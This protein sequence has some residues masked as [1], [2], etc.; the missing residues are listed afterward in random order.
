[1]KKRTLL[2]AMV[3]IVGAGLFSSGALAAEYYIAPT[4][5]S[6]TASSG[7]L[8]NPFATF[9]YAIGRLTPG[10]TLY[11]RGGTYDLSSK[12]SISSSKSGTETLP[13]TLAAYQSELPIL[14]FSGESSGAQGIQLDGNYWTIQGLT[15][16][17]ARDS[18]ILI[19]G[20]YNLINQLTLTSNQDSG[21]QISGSGSLHPSNNLILNTDSYANYDAA[22]HGENADG[23]AAKFRDLGTGNVFRGVRAWG[24]SDD[25]FD[26]W[27]AACGVT[28]E[29]SW[30]FNNGF[31]NWGDTAWAG[32]GNGVKLG[33]DSGT[34][35]IQNV[36]VWGN[37][38]NGIDVNG[39]AT[40]IEVPDDPIDHG[41]IVEN[42]TAYNNG[43][44]GANKTGYNFLFDESFAH[45]V[46]NNVA[47]LGGKGNAN[48]YTG[49][50]ND[51][52]SWNGLTVSA[53]DF[54]S[55]DDTIATGPRQADGSLPVSDFLQLARGSRLIDAGVDVG[56]PYNGNAPDLGAFESPPPVIL[57]W[58][59]ATSATWDVATANWYNT[60]TSAADKFY[61]ADAV[62]LSD[63][64]NGVNAPSTA[65]I[66][67]SAT[68][69]P[70]SVA[71]DASTLSYSISGAGR[72]SGNTSLVKSGAGTLTIATAN[73]YTG[74]TVINGGILSISANYGLGANTG[75]LTIDRTG[76]APAVLRATTSFLLATNRPITIG[77]GGGAI[78]VLG[79]GHTLSL[80]PLSTTAVT[81]DGPLAVQGG[82]TLNMIFAAAPT[83]S[84]GASLSIAAGTTLNVGGTGDP[85]TYGDLHMD[86]ANDG[87]LNIIANSKHLGA[88][89]GAGDTTLAAGTQLIAASVIQNT[90]TIGAGAKLTITSFAG[91]TLGGAGTLNAVPEPSAWVLL[92]PAAM[93]LGLYWRRRQ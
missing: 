9:S 50:V 6:D 48:I 57:A 2:M 87:S 1:M 3:L 31:N 74:G 51:H 43:W 14:D 5:G 18:G 45:V 90:L 85:F 86:V 12:I 13:Y 15:I 70:S 61:Q 11:V 39:N 55:L 27:E 35:L 47:Y 8:A 82:G 29:N 21:L 58:S 56:T 53:S 52:N 79:A 16:Q 69:Y 66:T 49:V 46:R 20:S 34:H 78:E 28:V 10:D 40:A 32:D 17:N 33:H 80:A 73:D 44:D 93:G 23:F 68:V 92:M 67:L 62:R 25:G 36:V 71:C 75:L 30:A 81:F 91:G 59:G 65:A 37:R 89:S 88:L 64:Y 41:V 84:A 76:A 24:N 26:F 63:T 83:I 54:L 77:A 38:L 42:V 19:R 60:D 7:T 4:G 22:N 72:I